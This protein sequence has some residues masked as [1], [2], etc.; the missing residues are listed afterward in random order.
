MARSRRI[1]ILAESLFTVSPRLGLWLSER[2]GLHFYRRSMR[3]KQKE[4]PP[5]SEYSA[6]FPSMTE[7][8]IGE[9]TRSFALAQF[10]TDY[11]RDVAEQGKLS[12]VIPLVRW[13]N[14]ELL[15]RYKSEGKPVIVTTWHAGP[16][17]G[18]WAALLQLGVSLMKVQGITWSATP[19]NWTIIEL[20]YNSGK[21]GIALKR[22]LKHLRKGGWVALTCDTFV[23]MPGDPLLPCLGRWVA[24][25]RGVAVLSVMSGAPVVPIAASW[26]EG[27]RAVEVEVQEP[28]QPQ[29]AEGMS[30]AD[31]ELA[32]LREIAERREAYLRRHPDSMSRWW[33]KYLSTMPRT[34]QYDAANA[35]R[36]TGDPR[37]RARAA[38]GFEQLPPEE[39]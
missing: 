9:L 39:G 13:K 30:D 38:A 15:E 14:R 18:I 24:S 25:P 37:A 17:I 33:V 34:D 5:S 19:P 21:L 12:G 4:I 20:E 28:V 31:Y 6:L 32:I 23:A 3:R 22:C 26:V 2:R 36:L 29:C 1:K 7:R 8:E 16:S 11:L 27:G 35:P 10:R